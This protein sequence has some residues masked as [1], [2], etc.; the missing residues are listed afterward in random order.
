M[1]EDWDWTIDLR[2]KY[3]IHDTHPVKDCYMEIK[4]STQKVRFIEY[5]SNDPKCQDCGAYKS[6]VIGPTHTKW[7][8][9][10]CA[11]YVGEDEK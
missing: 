2:G 8:C 7:V 4:P 3:K 9:C 6:E 1:K 10:S 11:I 5:K